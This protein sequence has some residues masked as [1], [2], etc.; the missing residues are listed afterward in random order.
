MWCTTFQGDATK[1]A[2]FDADKSRRRV[3][4]C[5]ECGSPVEVVLDRTC[6]ICRG[7]PFHR[8]A[9]LG[10]LRRESWDLIADAD[11]VVKPVVATCRK[12]FDRYATK[13]AK[14]TAVNFDPETS[15]IVVYPTE[16]DSFRVKFRRRW[17]RFVGTLD[18]RLFNL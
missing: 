1:A 14:A 17:K 5:S 15:R 7:R 11:A 6:D 9:L 8:W 2:F 3:Y 18:L 13:S 4:F 16:E 12:C 10:M